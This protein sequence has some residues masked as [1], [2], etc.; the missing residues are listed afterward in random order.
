MDPQTQELLAIINSLSI[1]CA[2][3][4]REKAEMQA[5]YQGVMARR[6]PGEEQARAA[7]LREVGG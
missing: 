3:L 4:A 1:R 5:H 2:T 6:E 7:H